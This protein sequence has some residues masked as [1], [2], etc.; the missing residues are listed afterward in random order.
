MNANE[1]KQKH[2]KLNAF[3]TSNYSKRLEKLLREELNACLGSDDN[4]TNQIDTSQIHIWVLNEFAVPNNLPFHSNIIDRS[5]TVRCKY[6]H[7]KIN[8]SIYKTKSACLNIPIDNASANV[9][10]PTSSPHISLDILPNLIANEKSTRL[11][12]ETFEYGYSHIHGFY[13]F[14][15][16]I[17]FSEY[18]YYF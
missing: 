2:E 16:D 9:A 17:H 8:D 4:K 6:G 11:A 5:N 3:L 10:I 18:L 12:C 7:M 1:R 14:D 13:A 15:S